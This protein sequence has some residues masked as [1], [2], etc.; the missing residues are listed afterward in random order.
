MVQTWNFHRYIPVSLAQEGNLHPVE[1]ETQT[2][3]KL[4][5]PPPTIVSAD[6]MWQGSGGV[7]LVGVANQCLV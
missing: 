5:N 7:E 3:T 4:Q 1:R 6:K 2:P